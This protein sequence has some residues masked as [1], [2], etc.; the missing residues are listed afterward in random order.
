M[1]D[2]TFNEQPLFAEYSG[3]G[4]EYRIY[5]P[6]DPVNLH[7]A[8]LVA[9]G[10]SGRIDNFDK[11]EHNKNVDA[12][13]RELAQRGMKAVTFSNPGHGG[14]TAP[15]T[16]D[17]CIQACDYWHSRF[18]EEGFDRICGL[19][20]SLGAYTL[21]ISASRQD[22]EALSLL[23][24]P[25]SL[26]AVIGSHN[27]FAVKV[28]DAIRG[29][30]LLEEFVGRAV[31]AW[32]NAVMLEKPLNQIFRNRLAALRVDSFSALAREIG[33]AP[34]LSGYLG[35]ITTDRILAA[36]MEPDTFIYPSLTAENW[37]EIQMEWQSQKPSAKVMLLPGNHILGNYRQYFTD[38]AF[39]EFIEA[40][41]GL[42]LQ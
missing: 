7:G 42:F 2:V 30:P 14:T 29:N 13:A 41:A 3:G 35:R 8:A 27:P 1:P 20:H 4:L 31:L 16:M 9:I 22:Y 28:Y 38:E 6:A 23:G 15:F 11:P 24:P 37:Q 33:E 25:L 12:L 19:G 10:I 36:Y 34:S 21:S 18:A 39:H 40:T 17:N 32:M 5:Q 26:K